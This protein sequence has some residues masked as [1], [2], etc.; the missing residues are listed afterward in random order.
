MCNSPWPG[1]SDSP[2]TARRSAAAR[3]IIAPTTSAPGLSSGAKRLR[4]QLDQIHKAT[5]SGDQAWETESASHL[6]KSFVQ[7]GT[8]SST[9]TAWA[10]TETTAA[11]TAEAAAA[12]N[13][14]V[15]NVSY[16]SGYAAEAGGGA[17]LI[18]QHQLTFTRFDLVKLG[19]TEHLIHVFSGSGNDAI[20]EM[21]C[22]RDVLAAGRRSI[23][24]LGGLKLKLD[25]RL[26]QQGAPPVS[27]SVFTAKLKGDNVML[28]VSSAWFA[29]Q[30]LDISVSDSLEGPGKEEVLVLAAVLKERAGS[31]VGTS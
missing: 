18:S 13:A 2:Q 11:A 26:L 4:E 12:S 5:D 17:L 6:H 19:Q 31:Q 15:A 25:A 3:R 22:L 7:I 10:A 27:E 21:L 29:A 14:A 16:G 28:F 23:N 8:L 24:D 1:S 30:L 20:P 9:P